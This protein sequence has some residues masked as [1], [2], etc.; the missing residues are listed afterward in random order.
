MANHRTDEK[1]GGGDDNDKDDLDDYELW[2]EMKKTVK[3]LRE[4]MGTRNK[5]TA[6]G[7]IL[8]AANSTPPPREPSAGETAHLLA[9]R[10]DGIKNTPSMHETLSEGKFPDQPAQCM[11]FITDSGE[12]LDPSL[13]DMDIQK[14]MEN[15]SL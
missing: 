7:H 1:I 9:H 2:R 5:R 12:I 10:P 6:F 3:I 13:S 14:M 4:D 11:Q 8:E 15:T